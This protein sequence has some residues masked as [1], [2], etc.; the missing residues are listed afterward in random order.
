MATTPACLTTMARP[1]HPQPPPKEEEGKENKKSCLHFRLH[2]FTPSTWQKDV[3]LQSVIDLIQTDPGE[4]HSRFKMTSLFHKSVVVHEN[5]RHQFVSEELLSM[6]IRIENSK[7]KHNYHTPI[8]S[9][10]TFTY[11]GLFSLS[12]DVEAQKKRRQR[13][14]ENKPRAAPARANRALLITM[15]RNRQLG[16]LI[17]MIISV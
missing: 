17:L 9:F 3:F 10:P 11:W 6:N 8:I 12:C 7:E 1:L 5:D 16:Q 14:R 2:L 13:Q 4:S 15:K